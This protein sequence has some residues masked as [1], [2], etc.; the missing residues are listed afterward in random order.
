MCTFT[1]QC[2][3]GL[4]CARPAEDAIS[5]SCAP[6]KQ[7]GAPCFFDDE[8]SPGSRCDYIDDTNRRCAAIG[9]LSCPS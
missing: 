5:G 1:E 4:T 6:L 8:C 2:A 9:P 7:D 3:L